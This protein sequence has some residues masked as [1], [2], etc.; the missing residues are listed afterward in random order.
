MYGKKSQPKHRK[1]SKSYAPTK[2]AKVGKA[3]KVSGKKF[4]NKL[5]SLRQ[6]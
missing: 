4:M 6:N 2:T 3:M 5:G 1:G